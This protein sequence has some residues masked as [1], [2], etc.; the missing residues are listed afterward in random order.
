MIVDVAR[1]FMSEEQPCSYAVGDLVLVT[2]DSDSQSCPG[3]TTELHENSVQKKLWKGL[4]EISHDQ[5]GKATY[6]IAW[7]MLLSH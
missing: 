5:K 1:I 4:V 6:T 2:Y 3:E 7:K